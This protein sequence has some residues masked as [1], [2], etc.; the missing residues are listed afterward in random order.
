MLL[1][2]LFVLAVAAPAAVAAV[3]LPAKPGPVRG[4]PADRMLKIAMDPIEYDGAR[5]CDKR[6]KPGVVA[7]TRWLQRNAAGQFWGSYRCEKWGKDSASLHAENRAIDWHLDV[8]DPADRRAA[9]A[10]IELLLAPDKAG[11]PQALA[12]R[13][14]IEEL[15]WDCSYWGAGMVQFQDYGP[16]FNKRGIRRKHV[17]PTV[18]HNDHIHIGMTKRGAAAKT[19]F[20]RGR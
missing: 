6:E 7:F 9:R 14:G 11:T 13:M 1:V 10:L 4:N 2:A 17:N 20:W 5:R 19:S 18:A 8:R 15:I 12:R 3:R 16:C